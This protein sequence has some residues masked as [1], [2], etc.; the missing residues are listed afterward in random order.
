MKFLV[1]LVG[2][3]VVKASDYEQ[4]QDF[5]VKFSKSHSLTE[6]KLRFGIFQNNLRKIEVHN[7]LYEKGEVS[8]FLKVTQFADWTSEE[9]KSML[10][11]Q[12]NGKPEISPIGRFKPEANFTRPESI[13]WRQKGAVLGVKAQGDCG[14]CWAF[15]TTG[16]LEG[17]LAIHRNQYIPLSEQ[18]LVSCDKNNHACGGGWIDVP[19]TYLEQNG[20]SSEEQY[21]Y[22]GNEDSCINNIGNKPLTTVQGFISIKKDEESMA[23]AVATVGPISIYVNANN[24]W[25]LYGGGVFDDKDCADFF[26]HAVIITGYDSQSWT[27]KNSWGTEWG[28]EGYMRLIRGKNQCGITIFPIYPVL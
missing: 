17:Q 4:W 19:Y 26:N 2:I 9:F 12:L 18:E 15:S 20:L 13:D 1:L 10:G 8:Y 28:E 11:A 16:A 24:G 3:I 22:T 6:D 7:A 25:Q 21:P 27:I 5:K 14:S 23:D